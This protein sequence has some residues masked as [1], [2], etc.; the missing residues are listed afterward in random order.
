MGS[1]PGKGKEM[2]QKKTPAKKTAGKK[3]APKVMARR[4]VKA[5]KPLVAK[6][7]D[8][9]QMLKFMETMCK[10]LALLLKDL[11]PKLTVTLNRKHIDVLKAMSELGVPMDSQLCHPVRA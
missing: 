3:A 1:R 4:P 2:A 11:D 9:T 5:N 8:L 7:E 6:K 10:F